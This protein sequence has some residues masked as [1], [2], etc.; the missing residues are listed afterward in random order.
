MSEFIL[1]TANLP[2]CYFEKKGKFKEEGGT[3]G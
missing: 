2:K 1:Q 3:R